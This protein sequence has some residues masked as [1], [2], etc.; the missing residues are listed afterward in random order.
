MGARGSG[1]SCDRPRAAAVCANLMV[2]GLYT[3]FNEHNFGSYEAMRATLEAELG[4]L[5]P[6]LE[7]ER[8][9]VQLPAFD[10]HHEDQ[11]TAGAATD[12]GM[13]TIVPGMIVL[14]YWTE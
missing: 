14:I 7:T 4:G 9:R 2:D 13:R 12:F 1:A 10:D 3:L 6:K 11:P 5:G 8:A